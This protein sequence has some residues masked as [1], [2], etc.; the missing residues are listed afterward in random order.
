M[1]NTVQAI[2]KIEAIKQK[3]VQVFKEL[4]RRKHLP[5]KKTD[6]E[7]ELETNVDLIE[8]HPKVKEKIKQNIKIKDKEKEEVLMFTIFQK[9]RMKVSTKSKKIQK[10][11]MEIEDI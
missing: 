5:K 8:R 11:E 6:I 1:I 2:K 10:R 7:R 9:Q 3:R 4:K